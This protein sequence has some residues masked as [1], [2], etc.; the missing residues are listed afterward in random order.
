[1][2]SLEGRA[3]VCL[4]AGKGLGRG[5]AREMAAAGAQTLLVSRNEEHL[6]AAAAGIAADLEDTGA[7]PGV[8]K[9]RRPQILAADLLG[10]DAAERIMRHAGEAFGG[11]DILLNNIGGPP[12]GT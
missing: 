9:W 12:S 8:A 6:R 11:I 7:Y 2:W 3:A 4:A 10:E 1:M 5:I